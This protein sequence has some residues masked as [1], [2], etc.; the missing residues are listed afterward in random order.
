MV[1]AHKKDKDEDWDHFG[2]SEPINSAPPW[3]EIS[4]QGELPPEEPMVQEKGKRQ[5]AG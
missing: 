5:S 1:K 4:E 2:S 3:Y